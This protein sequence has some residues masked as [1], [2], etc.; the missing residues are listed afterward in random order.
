MLQ[1]QGEKLSMVLNEAQLFMVQLYYEKELEMVK[2]LICTFKRGNN[3]KKHKHKRRRK[4]K[5]CKK[6]LVH[7]S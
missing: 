2:K 4:M 1:N 7:N 3:L 6:F 5:K